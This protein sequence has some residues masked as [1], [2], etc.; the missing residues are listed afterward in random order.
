MFTNFRAT[1]NRVIAPHEVDH[2]E[3]TTEGHAEKGAHE[4]QG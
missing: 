4:R 3:F 1:I 2:L